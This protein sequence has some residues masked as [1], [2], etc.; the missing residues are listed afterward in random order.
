MLRQTAGLVRT[1]LV[2]LTIVALTFSTPAY[3]AVL[4]L[5]GPLS[6]NHDVLDFRV[7]PDGKWVA[8]TTGEFMDAFISLNVVPAT[9]GTPMVRA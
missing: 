5:S 1:V 9:G 8:Y 6:P 7:S 4:K 2:V 3:A